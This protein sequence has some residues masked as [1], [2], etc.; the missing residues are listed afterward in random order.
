M[1]TQRWRFS[2]KRALTVGV[3]CTFLFE[4]IVPARLAIAQQPAPSVPGQVVPGAPS[5]G[6]PGQ[7]APTPSMPGQ[8]PGRP[9]TAGPQGPQT[10]VP[11]PT[12]SN[13]PC[14][15]GF[16]P[17]SS[18]QPLEGLTG[19]TAPATPTAPLATPAG[20]PGT[21]PGALPTRFPAPGFPGVDCVPI[22]GAEAVPPAPGASFPLSSRSMPRPLATC[23]P[24][25]TS[26][27]MRPVL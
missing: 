18:G 10:G 5:G 11:A 16:M 23:V 22:P 19:A 25:V 12:V 26:L 9:G 2:A 8:V 15:P 4:S 27:E 3:I 20:A 24:A 21:T 6:L 1:S 14:P 17:V 7:V 13:F